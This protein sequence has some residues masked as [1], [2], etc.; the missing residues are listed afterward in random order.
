MCHSK[1][2]TILQITLIFCS[3]IY[4]S[5]EKSQ[6]NPKI[7]V[8]D[9]NGRPINPEL[10]PPLFYKTIKLSKYCINEMKKDNFKY[11][12]SPVFKFLVNDKE[13]LQNSS[14]ELVHDIEKEFENEV[15]NHHPINL[16][17][18][19]SSI[20][21]STP[22]RPQFCGMFA[23]EFI[24]A[25]TYFYEYLGLYL[26]G[27]VPVIMKEDHELYDEDYEKSKNFKFSKYDFD[28]VYTGKR[29]LIDAALHG[30]YAR[31]IN[32]QDQANVRA[33]M[34]GVSTEVLYKN[35]IIP[36][37]H[38]EKLPDV[39]DIITLTT[40]EDVY[41]GEELFLNYGDLYWDGKGY[42]KLRQ[43]DFK[44][45]DREVNGL[46]EEV[47]ELREENEKLK[48]KMKNLN[49]KVNFLLSNRH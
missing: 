37:E 46:Q 26:I 9:K 4:I 3:T 15:F 49:S 38:F 22:G 21:T 14:Y 25:E 28:Y 12:E 35:G 16:E 6:K 24:P 45:F 32:H 41:P 36:K 18:K 47:K 29:D 19:L 30:N 23:K 27:G 43:Y 31:M 40:S 2:L 42:P 48:K 13:P 10:R 5:A 17:I 8:K 7:K 1:M 11:S 34:Y 33:D 20:A 39:I 44:M